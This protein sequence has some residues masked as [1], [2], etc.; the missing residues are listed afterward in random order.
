MLIDCC[1]PI[2]SQ[3]TPACMALVIKMET[4]AVIK[5]ILNAFH[6]AESGGTNGWFLG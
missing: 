4:S 3:E 2:P 6:E 5:I 1:K